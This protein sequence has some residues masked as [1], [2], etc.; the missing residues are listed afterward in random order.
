M[1]IPRIKQELVAVH[2]LAVTNS[3][4]F[5]HLKV[6]APP[7]A[8]ASTTTAKIDTNTAATIACICTNA[9]LPIIIFAI[10]RK[11]CMFPRFACVHKREAKHMSRLPFSPNREGTRM[12]N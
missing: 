10:S 6:Y 4:Q 7:S 11:P 1:I 9:I 8:I 12:N 2:T 3:K 5:S